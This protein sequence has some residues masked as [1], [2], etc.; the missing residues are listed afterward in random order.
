MLT[1]PA[2]VTPLP[3]TTAPLP[4][5]FATMVELTIVVVADVGPK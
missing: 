2:Q 3:P 1:G 4:A 5:V